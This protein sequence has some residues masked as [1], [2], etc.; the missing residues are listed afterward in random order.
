M[1]FSS[2]NEDS[3]S[4]FYLHPT[5]NHS[6]V[7]VQPES[8]SVNYATWRRSFLLAVSIRNKQGFLH[9]YISKPSVADT[10]FNAWARYD[11]KICQLQ[12]KLCTITQGDKSI[13]TYVTEL[14]A[15]WGNFNVID[16]Y[17]I[18]LNGLKETF[19]IQR[20]QVLN[21]KSFPNIDQAYN[22]ILRDESQRTLSLHKLSIFDT[23]AATAKTKR[24]LDL[25]C[26][27]CGK[28]G[29]ERES[30]F[31]FVGY[32]PNFKFKNAPTRNPNLNQQVSRSAYNVQDQINETSIMIND[33]TSLNLSH[34]QI[35]KLYMLLNDFTNASQ[36]NSAPQCTLEPLNTPSGMTIS[37][38][39]FAA[40]N[41]QY[42]K[43]NAQTWIV[44][45]GAT[46]HIVCSLELFSTYKHVTNW[47]VQLPNGMKAPITHIQYVDLFSKLTIHN[48]LMAP[49]FS[50][51]L[52]SDHNTMI[53]IGQAKV[54][55][56]LYYLQLAASECK[57][58][59]TS[60]VSTITANKID[61]RHFSDLNGNHY[62]LTIFDDYFKVTWIYMLKYKSQVTNI[63]AQFYQLV[64]TQFQKPPTPVL[65]NIS[66]YE[67]LYHFKPN[68]SHF[69][70]FVSLCFVTNV[71]P[72]RKKFDSRAIKCIFLGYP[73]HT[74]GYKS[75]NDLHSTVLPVVPP[76]NFTH[77]SP[78]LN[79]HSNLSNP[80]T[81]SNTT[82]AL[83]THEELLALNQNNTW[84]IVP[85]PSGLHAIRSK[86]V[87]KV[88]FHSNGSIECHRA[89]LVAK[90]YTQRYGFDYQETFSLGESSDNPAAKLVCK[91]NKSLYGLKQAFRQWNM[92]FTNSLLTQ[93]FT[94]S[95]Y[96]CS[97]FNKSDY[98]G[99]IALL[100]YADD[101]IIA[102]SSISVISSIKAFLASQLKLKDLGS[103][104]YFIGL[105]IE[106][107]HFGINLCKLLYLTL[108]RLN[109]T[110][111]VHVLTQFM[112]KPAAIHLQSAM[113]VLRYLKGSPGQGIY[114]SSTAILQM[115]AYCDSDWTGCPETRRFLTGYCI[116]LA[117]SLISWKSKKQQ[118][119]SRNST[120]A[121]YT[122]MSPA[123][124][125]VT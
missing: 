11:A 89:R 98:T 41:A 16:L 114:F 2:Q 49:S 19:Q 112:D 8:N 91:L 99:F 44:D 100:L 48:V 32:P 50:F 124:S 110:Y 102:S 70:V 28:Q 101:I 82:S 7:I 22:M 66:P 73:M 72:H 79:S 68:Y 122:S 14:N 25:I 86:L 85:L 59:N 58:I 5:D 63:V 116:F 69:K 39:T 26:S 119:V 109:I 45:T 113:T 111:D 78:T 62:C 24:K 10:Q 61:L 76:Y 3:A 92:K 27:N 36:C 1:A 74:K 75:Q 77:P 9:G 53:R 88:K 118:V 81:S 37:P 120:E 42:G 35:Q 18:F 94:Q 12:H 84:S 51:N 33:Q 93:G 40:M 67:V 23:V 125:E 52:L 4:P 95:K 13:D 46:D 31:R 64:L 65:N 106:R 30:C 115:R 57:V 104:K 83:S 47:N 17:H 20:S 34:E 96:D 38:S 60:V 107:D 15:I 56:G 108:T 87:Y 105:E 121:E 103:I 21:T 55:Q 80:E 54:L 71:D 43:V 29:H 117:S 6:S 90:G 123:A 97:L